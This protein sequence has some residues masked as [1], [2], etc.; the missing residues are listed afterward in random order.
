MRILMISDV[1]FPRI[2]GVSTS[3]DTFAK[4]FKQQG[5]VVDLIA[6]EYSHTK[7]QKQVI[8]NIQAN[9]V[10]DWIYRI[11]SKVVPFDPE[12]RLMSMKKIKDLL[13]I[14]Q[15]NKYDV[16]HIHTPFLAH[17]AGVWLAKHLNI[18]VVETYH[19]FFEE[20]LYHY[21]P[22]LPKSLL[23]LLA[24]KFSVSQCKQIDHIVVPSQPM[25]DVLKDYGVNTDYAI[26]PTGVDIKKPKENAGLAFRQKY[27]ISSEQ[28]VLVHIGRVAF[29]KNID[30]L[31]SVTASMVNQLPDVLLVV[32]GEGPALK[33]LKSMAEKLNITKN[34]KFVGYLN[35]NNDLSG[36][37]QAGDVFVFSSR[38]ETQG[39]VLLEA[40]MLGVPVVSTA[41][42][43]TKDILI[44]GRGALIAKEEVSDFADKVL[45]IL[46]DPILMQSL[47]NEGENYAQAWQ[48]HEMAKR[49]INLYK[50]L[51]ASRTCV[52]KPSPAC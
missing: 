1:F 10:E 14:L 12:D 49:M 38:T 44:N 35:R 34:V 46:K 9:S 11:P 28:P 27:G 47:S 16:L 32:A 31:L 43:G 5:H 52:S 6:P 13:P 33:H 41:K 2:N 19:T 45:K 21:V 40:M 30:F 37:Y 23:K 42:M 3:I 48:P 25:A 22:V 29:E 20:Y 18:P 24:R 4:E 7:L 39:L 8:N 36:C 17:Y 15:T 50:N 26:L 51:H